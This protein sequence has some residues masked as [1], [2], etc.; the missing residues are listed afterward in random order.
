MA[1]IRCLCLSITLV[2]TV[3]GVSSA[4]DALASAERLWQAAMANRLSDEQAEAA[5][6]LLDH[7]DAFVRGLAQWAIA[8]KVGGENNGQTAVR[9]GAN[10]P[11][12]LTKWMAVGALGRV[13][14]DWVW[15]AVARGIHRDAKRLRADI[16]VMHRRAER[17]AAAYRAA[18]AP[19]AT[20]RRVG[21]EV[22]KLGSL[23]ADAASVRRAWLAGRRAMRAIVLANPAV[24]FDRI[25]FVQRF[26]PHTVRNITRS[27][28]WKHK[29]GGDICILSDFAAGGRVRGVLGGRL[30]PG[31][32]WG[33]DLWWDADR[34]V[35]GYAKLPNWPPPVDTTNPLTEGNNVFALRKRFEPLHVFEAPL[36][37]GSV[38]QVTHD[39]YWSD[40]EPTYLA[41]GGIVF[42]SDRCGRSAECGQESYDHANPNLYVIS[43]GQTRPRKLTDSKDIDR[44]PHSLANGQIGYT[45]WEYQE[46]H[47]MEVHAVWTIRP[48]GRMADALFKHHMPAPLAL[49][50]TRSVPGSGKLVA[51]ATGHHTFAYGPVVLVD[52]EVGFNSPGGIEV[53]T[54]G[55]RPQEGPPAGRKPPGGGAG[56]R[57]GLYQTPWALSQDCFLVA[58]SYARP[59][60]TARAGADSNGFGLY[61]IDRWGNR[62]LLHRDGLLSCCF[63][64]P[65]R[66]RRRPP[67]LPAVAP[68]ATGTC[69]LADVYAG[70]E[71]VRRGTIKYLR[72][73]QHVGWPL[74]ERRGAMH[75]IPGQAYKRQFGFWSWSPVRVIGT[76]PVSADGSAAFH[77]PADTA[78]YF[79]ALDADHMEVVRM[80][81]MVS[82]KSGEVRGCRG[83]H[84]TRALAPA[85]GKGT[86]SALRTPPRTPTPPPWGADRLLGYEWLVQP[87]FTKHCVR[88]HGG[89]K[90]KAA[91]VLTDK[92]TDGG[93]YQSYR[94]LLGP[95]T[96]RKKPLVACSDRFSNSAVTRPRQFGSHKSRL[97][98]MLHRDVKHKKRVRLS[99]AEWIA[100]TTWVDA[101]APYYDAFHNKR[102]AGGE[103]PGRTFVPDLTSDGR[104]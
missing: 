47:F 97:I 78:V 32:A 45:H 73:S 82:L 22:H 104:R 74:D 30:G 84:E 63:P 56:D 87:I 100:L 58:Y 1:V 42:A 102:P 44:Y 23:R 89:A 55:V 34:V 61:V 26:V 11:K 51:I 85:G 62:E 37:G 80:R 43:P 86:P 95:R 17:M 71:G 53:L 67:V 8:M 93:M 27:Y 19:P 57:G 103:R 4:G 64:I 29:P 20:L 33:L 79:Q 68:A 10:P 15:Q 41:D 59:K 2:L 81:S 77:V 7:A 9:P 21:R 98:H 54:P 6:E 46:R 101:N 65:L 83:C 50:D 75:Y 96:G 12:W 92:R 70:L 99:R 88:C 38:R 94:S 14:A 28:S 49:R 16:A 69:Y 18:G 90:P 3:A 5:G 25:V 48:D 35:F 91:L 72:I 39:A 36:D 76:V 13:E 52:P 31:Y 40:F 66:R 24:D 60:C